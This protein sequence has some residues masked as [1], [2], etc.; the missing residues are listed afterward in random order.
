MA[1]STRVRSRMVKDTVMVS[2]FG[3]MV[4][5]MKDTGEITWPTVE[6]NSIT[7]METSMMVTFI[8]YH[9]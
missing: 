4:L 7:S 3:Q 9:I 8:I 5:S 1:R 2:K 6:E